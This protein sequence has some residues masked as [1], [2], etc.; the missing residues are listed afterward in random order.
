MFSNGL[1]KIAAAKKPGPLL[2]DSSAK[3][4]AMHGF[5]LK[6]LRCAKI[7]LLRKTIVNA[8]FFEAKISHKQIVMLY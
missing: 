2:K 4:S 3:V 1:F 5:P 6:D 8:V 7:A